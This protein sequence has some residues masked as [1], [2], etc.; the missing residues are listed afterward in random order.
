[1]RNKKPNAGRKTSRRS[2]PV[3]LCTLSYSTSYDWIRYLLSRC[4]ILAATC[5]TEVSGFR[6]LVGFSMVTYVAVAV[7][8]VKEQIYEPFLASKLALAR[9]DKVPYV[10]E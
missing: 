10:R 1:M 2:S 5:K 6:C 3:P 7:H 8:V 9:G 4:S